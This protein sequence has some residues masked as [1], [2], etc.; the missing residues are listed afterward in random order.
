MI[1]ITMTELQRN[2]KLISQAS[3]E[4]QILDKRKNEILGVYT[5]TIK[6]EE[7]VSID[8]IAGSLSKYVTTEKRK[9]LEGK[10]REEIREEARTLAMEKKYGK[11]K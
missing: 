9:E 3:E 4:V 5:P 10:T 11:K 8:D 6:N 1:S 2:P 7:N